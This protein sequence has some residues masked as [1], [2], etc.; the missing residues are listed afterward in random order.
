MH[1]DLIGVLITITVAAVEVIEYVYEEYV[2]SK[3]STEGEID[4]LQSQV[5]RIHQFLF[6]LEES[7]DKGRAKQTKEEIM[8]LKEQLNRIESNTEEN[9]KAIEKNSRELEKESEKRQQEHNK[10]MD[11]LCDIQ[12]KVENNTE[13]IK[14]LQ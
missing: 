3:E 6:G 7:S 2:S 9:R 11:K 4:E 1:W 13:T 14:E 8:G 10:A 12:E 5:Q